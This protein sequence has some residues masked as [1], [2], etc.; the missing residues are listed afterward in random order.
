MIFY[1]PTQGDFAPP[2]ASPDLARDLVSWSVWVPLLYVWHALSERAGASKMMK[3][4]QSEAGSRQASPLV[5]GQAAWYWE[6]YKARCWWQCL[7]GRF[8]GHNQ[9]RSECFQVQPVACWHLSVQCPGQMFWA[10]SVKI[11]VTPSPTSYMLTI[12][13]GFFSFLDSFAV[14]S[15]DSLNWWVNLPWSLALRPVSSQPQ[16]VDL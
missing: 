3:R 1:L 10:Q 15:L 7:L 9:S 4:G 8:F 16:P 12:F 6:I 5:S 2:Y 14:Y 11:L 13:C